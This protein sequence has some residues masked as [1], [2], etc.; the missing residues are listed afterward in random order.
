MTVTIKGTNLE[1]TPALKQYAAEKVLS[2]G[3]FF[4]G[5]TIARLELERT[6]RHHHKGEVWR[7]EGNLHGPHHLF[8]AE[9]EAADI[10]AAVDRMKDELKRELHAS[11]EKRRT[12]VRQ[13]RWMKGAGR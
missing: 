8:R 10:Y 7:A 6:T 2:L 1:L 3:K 9:A 4:P 11:K 12:Q 5:L 13:A